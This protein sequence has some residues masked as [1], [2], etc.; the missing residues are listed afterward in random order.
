MTH[1]EMEVETEL[2]G[3]LDRLGEEMQQS[4]KRLRSSPY[5]ASE[6]FIGRARR[7]LKDIAVVGEM[8]KGEQYDAALTLC[9]LIEVPEI[10]FTEEEVEAMGD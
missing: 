2:S 6:E 9:K 7:V 3:I 4:A 1:D 10:E 8:L 5:V